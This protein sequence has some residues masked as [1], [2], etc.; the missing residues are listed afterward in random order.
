MQ[1][2]GPL[3]PLL[4]PSLELDMSINN[5]PSKFED[6]ANCADMVPVPLLM[7]DQN[8]SQ[9]SGGPMILEEDKSL[10]M[11]LALSSMDELVKMC[12]TGEPL[13]IRAPNDSGKE[14]LNVEEYS[15]MFPWPVGVKQN[16]NE[17]RIEATRSNAVVIMNSITLVDAF[18][19]TVSYIY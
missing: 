10:A 17:L 11:E 2:Q 8:N 19:D 4:P 5:F 3:T 12:T 18:L 15:R 14:V 6:Q 13:W 9:F 16:G 7:P 1:G